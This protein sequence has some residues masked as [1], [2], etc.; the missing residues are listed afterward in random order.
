MGLL[1]SPHDL[2]PFPGRPSG[3]SSPDAAKLHRRRCLCFDINPLVLDSSSTTRSHRAGP[4]GPPLLGFIERP[5]AGVSSR[6]HSGV[7]FR[8]PSVHRCHPVN[9]VPPSWFLSTST[10]FS[11]LELRVCC[12]PQPTMG[13]V[14]FPAGSCLPLR[15][16]APSRLSQRRFHT[17]RRFPLIDSRIASP[18]P[19]PSCRCRTFPTRLASD[20]TA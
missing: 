11:T 20:E 14:A 7:T 17:L 8:L 3:Y 13:F 1:R 18:R 9:L 15:V 10:A 2:C 6:V 5:F 12:T 19:L 4:R 16:W